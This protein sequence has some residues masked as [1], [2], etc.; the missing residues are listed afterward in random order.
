LSKKTLLMIIFITNI[1]IIFSGAIILKFVMPEIFEDYSSW[2][3][4]QIENCGTFKIPGDWKKIEENGFIEFEKSSKKA[5]MV[6]TYFSYGFHASAK[7]QYNDEY[8]FKIHEHIYSEVFSNSAAYSVNKYDMNGSYDKMF[9]VSFDNTNF[10]ISF[11]FI[12]PTID[13]KI[14]RKIAISFIPN[15]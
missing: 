8:N 6:Q 11:I 14:I 9:S 15:R 12:D 2:Q 1:F 10:G 7:Y 13:E 4:I 3:T 5:I